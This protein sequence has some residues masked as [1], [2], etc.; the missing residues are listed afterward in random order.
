M[1][2]ALNTSACMQLF[3][4]RIKQEEYKQEFFRQMAFSN[5]PTRHWQPVNIERSR[6]PALAER[7]CMAVAW[8][9]GEGAIGKRNATERGKKG[10]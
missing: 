6:E 1:G 3:F 5:L 8:L 9:R 2:Q 7:V 10:R 4:L